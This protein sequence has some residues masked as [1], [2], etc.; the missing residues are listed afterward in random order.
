M[1][2]SSFLNRDPAHTC[3]HSREIRNRVDE[4]D[5][6]SLVIDGFDSYSAVVFSSDIEISAYFKS[7]LIVFICSYNVGCDIVY[8]VCSIRSISQNSQIAVFE[9]FG[10]ERVAV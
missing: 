9:V 4:F 3:E 8:V 1:Y 2:G 5:L 6:K 10:C 7:F